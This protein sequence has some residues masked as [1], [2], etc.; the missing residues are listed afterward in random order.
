M[1]EL[2][3][4]IIDKIKKWKIKRKSEYILCPYCLHDYCEVVK[5]IKKREALFSKPIYKCCQCKA[6]F[7]HNG[8]RIRGDRFINK[9]LKEF[10][11]EIRKNE[12]KLDKETNQIVKKY[13][14]SNKKTYQEGLNKILETIILGSE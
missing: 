5:W 2:L 3:K 13:F 8:K 9:I 7:K 4:N 10:E 11:K 12:F 1:S 14:I 6:L